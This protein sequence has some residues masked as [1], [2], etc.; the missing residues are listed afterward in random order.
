MF[1]KPKS[2]EFEFQLV[3]YEVR[4]DYAVWDDTQKRFLRESDLL[5]DGV[6]IKS[7]ERMSSVVFAAKYPMMAKNRRYSCVRKIIVDEAGCLTEYDYGFKIT[8]NDDLNKSISSTRALGIN[9]LEVKYVLRKTGTDIDTTYSVIAS[10]R[11]GLP[12][13]PTKVPI[14]V[15]NRPTESVKPKIVF[16]V[17]NEQKVV[18]LNDIER[19]IYEAS[20]E[21]PENL[22]EE[23]YIELWNTCA[24][25][26]F[27][28]LFSGERIKE[29]YSE[30][31]VKVNKL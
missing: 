26:D 5:P 12:A 27:N 6:P 24:K 9:P 28:T 30:L 3:N 17:P 18:V 23:R 7:T 29:I 15:P 4:K 20:C 31:Y 14:A 21:Y 25:K 1:Y 13:E 16:G 2:N 8:A 22:T 19:Q 11:V 10:E